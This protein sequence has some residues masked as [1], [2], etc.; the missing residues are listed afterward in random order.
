[1]KSESPLPKGGDTPEESQVQLIS[2]NP[3]RKKYNYVFKKANSKWQNCEVT[4]FKI[5]ATLA[6]FLH[7]VLDKNFLRQS[8]ITAD[9]KLSN[10]I[11]VLQ[12]NKSHIF[13]KASRD[14]N[15]PL[16]IWWL[17]QALL[18]INEDR[19]LNPHML[20]R[21]HSPF[22]WSYHSRSQS[23]NDK[24]GALIEQISFN[25]FYWLF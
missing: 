16:Y 6:M 13:V 15:L 11:S 23:S 1:M 14:R 12:Q 2:H 24:Y 20:Q 4:F 17:G 21:F 8:Y 7:S 9:G 18:L 22:S 19:V 5:L 25:Q 3:N 10:L